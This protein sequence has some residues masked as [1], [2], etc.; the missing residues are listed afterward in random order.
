VN[1]IPSKVETFK[2]RLG[3]LYER[4][5]ENNARFAKIGIIGR[6]LNR[7]GD[8]F[9]AQT[10]LLTEAYHQRT[11]IQAWNFAEKIAAPCDRRIA[12]PATA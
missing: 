9:N 8:I 5:D 1:A 3:Q 2:S 6:A 12:R 4:I 10:G 7:P 11:L